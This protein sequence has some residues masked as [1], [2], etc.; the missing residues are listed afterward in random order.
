MIEVP[1]R[2][3]NTQLTLGLLAAVWIVTIWLLLYMVEP[4]DRPPTFALTCFV[5]I[6][7]EGLIFG[8]FTALGSPIVAP[9]IDPALLPSIGLLVGGYA[10]T[11]VVTVIIHN[12][13]NTGA[14]HTITESRALP[15]IYLQA[16]FFKLAPIAA[17]MP[18]LRSPKSFVSALALEMLAFLVLF[19]GILSV[20][21]IR[22]AE[23]RSQLSGL[24]TAVLELRAG[25]IRQKLEG[26]RGKVDRDR[27]EDLTDKIKRIEERFRFTRRFGGAAGDLDALELQISL[28]LDELLNKVEA[29]RSSTLES[30]P[31]TANDIDA[32]AAKTLR[33]MDV[34]DKLLIR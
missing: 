18:F 25:E 14:V 33:L 20:Q 10:L 26:L 28:L 21:T 3:A 12:L 34:R 31:S 13:S 7:Q 4:T 16:V 23:T 17:A 8:Y 11:T 19:R 9:R 1:A 30:A 15:A 29:S 27:F 24:S 2:R 6:V 32:L 5:L 22:S